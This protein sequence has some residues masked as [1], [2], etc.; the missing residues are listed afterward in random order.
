MSPDSLIEIRGVG[1]H[2]GTGSFGFWRATRPRR[3]ALADV[4]L[5]LRRG[6]ALGIVGESGSGKSTLARIVCGLEAAST[7]GV[8]Y[9]YGQGAD[10]AAS[11]RLAT[12]MVFQ[13]PLAALN[14]R[15]TIR[16]ALTYP[17][18]KHGVVSRRQADPYV[19]ELVRMVGLDE[20]VL[21]R[22]PGELSGG[23]R[24]RVVIARALSVKP[25]VLVCD[26]ATAS[27]DVSIQAQILNLLL[28]LRESSGMAMLFISHDLAVVRHICDR[29]CVMQAG[30]V[31]ETAQADLLFREPSSEYTRR[32]IDG[33]FHGKS[34]A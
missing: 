32:L 19:R 9:A 12:Q 6:E 31:V 14:P 5:T 8:E 22:L 25:K 10:R 7:G 34:V 4:S 29:V 20:S 21:G 17:A 13:D 33:A 24:Q 15:R 26:E 16:S 30:Q 2:Y 11:A 18:V 28:D 27:L 3:P 1:K 23:Q